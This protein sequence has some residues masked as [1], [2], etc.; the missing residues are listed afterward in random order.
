MQAMG[1]V[2]PVTLFGFV[3]MCAQA[4]N[5]SVVVDA[6]KVPQKILHVEE[7][8]PVKAGPLTIYYP[9]W[10]PGEHGPDGPVS[11]IANLKFDADGTAVPW[12]RDLLDIWTFHVDVPSGKT[13]LHVTFDYIE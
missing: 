9:K 7:V 2:L 5:I 11:N 3:A 12:T 6:T 10:I 8:L 4:Q 13:A 1:V